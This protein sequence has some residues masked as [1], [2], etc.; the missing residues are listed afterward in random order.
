VYYYTDMQHKILD[1]Q[2]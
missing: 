2:H 1:V